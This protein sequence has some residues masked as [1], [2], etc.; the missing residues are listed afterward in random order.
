M[1]RH[2]LF[3]RRY[4]LCAV[5]A[6]LFGC[7]KP[8]EV[9]A[10]P[11]ER[12]VMPGEV[13]QGHAKYEEECSR[14]HEPFSK[15]SQRL[16]CLS[17]H[18]E[19]NEDINKGMGFHGRNPEIHNI[20]CKHCHTDH[21]GRDADIMMLDKELFD[22]KMTDFELKGG[23]VKV[24]CS[25]CHNTKNRNPDTLQNAGDG[26][27]SPFKYRDAP[28][29][30]FDCHKDH[31][32]HRSQLGN[33]CADCHEEETWSKTRYNHD[34]TRFPLKGRHK[35]AACDKCH[36][37]ERW[38]KTPGDCFA[39]H[40]LNDSHRGRYGKKCETCHTPEERGTLPLRTDR[41]TRPITA[42]N[43]FIFDHSKTKYQ[44]IFKHRKIDCDK[45]HTGTIST[46]KLSFECYGC[47]K[48]DDVHRD[49][50]LEGR[51]CE[52]CHSERGWVTEVFFDHDLTRF[53]LIG[54][55]AIAPCEACHLSTNYKEAPL[56]A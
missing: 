40:R 52:H 10:A 15:T 54:L 45:C 56:T 38:A 37:G 39:C 7:W 14:C 20:E 31:D 12:L 50:G 46:E 18:K 9:R 55:H 27:A 42:W 23:H 28:S 34:K 41:T 36:P 3:R 5:L 51:K 48:K 24:P 11:V 43:R 4:F 33:K 35:E 47:H 49:K 2:T 53:P 30:C 13:I 44:L 32:P 22:H 21:K 17:C 8:A 26:N 25:G 6:L 16:L 29:Q 19:L 1:M